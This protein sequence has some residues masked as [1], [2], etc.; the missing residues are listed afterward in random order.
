MLFVWFCQIG[1]C[2]MLTRNLFVTGQMKIVYPDSVEI[3]IAKFIS[4]VVLH[5]ICLPQIK[6]SLEQMKFVVNHSYRFDA[7]FAAFFGAFL[8]LSVQVAVEVLNMCSL[9]SVMD[10]FEFVRDFTALI[11]IADFEK[12]MSLTLKEDCIKLLA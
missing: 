2:V 1:L 8:L 9:L 3:V 12:L 10:L 5:W 7:P 11:V 4:A 6:S